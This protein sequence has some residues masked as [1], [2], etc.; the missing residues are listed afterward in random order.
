LFVLAKAINGRRTDIQE[1]RR[2][3]LISQPLLFTSH[4]NS[5]LTVNGV[6]IQGNRAEIEM[7]TFVSGPG[8]VDYAARRAFLDATTDLLTPAPI[9]TLLDLL[10]LLRRWDASIEQDVFYRAFSWA[11]REIAD[12]SLEARAIKAAISAWMTQ[13][14]FVD[15][16]IADAALVTLFTH[17]QGWVDPVE[18]PGVQPRNCKVPAE[19]RKWY[20]QPPGS[21]M[22]PPPLDLSVAPR[23]DESAEQ[24]FTRAEQH[25]RR[26]RREGLAA[27]RFAKGD[28]A[29]TNNDQPAK[30]TVRRMFLGEDWKQIAP[31]KVKA[32]TVRKD[33][34]H[35]ILR[36]GLTLPAPEP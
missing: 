28:H 1:F 13:N 23:G 30:W 20:V 21:R 10:P 24:Y 33:V 25:V 9:D 19:P 7:A 5:I 3:T 22:N 14:R 6:R 26:A 32:D 36:A 16:W 2:I 29:S 18:K 31:P 4:N 35:F 12:D 27:L 34:K 15:Q 17:S 11:V 8:P